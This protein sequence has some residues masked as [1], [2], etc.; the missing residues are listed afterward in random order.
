MNTPGFTADWSLYTSSKTFLASNTHVKTVAGTKWSGSV[1]P[2]A[3]GCSPCILY[4]EPGPGGRTAG[5]RTCCRLTCRTTIFGTPR[6]YEYCTPEVCAT[7]S[8]GLIIV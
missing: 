3:Y 5:I 4:T 1:Q 8:P 7:F 6:C 2:A